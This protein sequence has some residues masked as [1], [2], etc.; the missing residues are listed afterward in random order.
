MRNDSGNVLFLILIGVALFA[1]L[2]YA[3]SRGSQVN[4]T[5][6]RERHS[7][8]ADQ[9]IR[10][11]ME[12]QQA[13]EIIMANGYSEGDISF[14]HADLNAAYVNANASD[15]TKVFSINGGGANYNP[16]K[17]SWQTSAAPWFFSANTC[18]PQIGDYDNDCINN[19]NPELIAFLPN[20]TQGVCTLINKKAGLDAAIPQDLNDAWDAATYYAGSPASG[21]AI[22]DAANS[23]SGRKIGCFQGG[24]IPLVGSYNAYIVLL[25]R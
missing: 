7:L 23:F 5:G 6:E 15:A 13:V 12:L 21:D 3:M 19:G 11:G 4:M 16:P 1:A 2:Q 18:V 25:A 24:N 14:E 8:S 9:I 22:N 20:V 10:Y 17:P